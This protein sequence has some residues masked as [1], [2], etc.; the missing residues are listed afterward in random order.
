MISDITEICSNETFPGVLVTVALEKAFD[1]LNHNFL[2]CAFKKFGF[3]DNFI[4][5]VLQMEGLL[6]IISR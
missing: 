5:P 6:L 4:N 1:S 2:S 3:D